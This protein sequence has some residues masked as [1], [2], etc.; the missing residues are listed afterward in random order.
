M[1]EEP[2]VPLPIVQEYLKQDTR[3]NGDV[4]LYQFNMARMVEEQLEKGQLEE[5]VQLLREAKGLPHY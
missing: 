2:L 1:G 3:M 5:A 4:L